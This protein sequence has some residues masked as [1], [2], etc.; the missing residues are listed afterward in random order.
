MKH[1]TYATILSLFVATNYITTAQKPSNPTP[2]QKKQWEDDAKKYEQMVR[3][4]GGKHLSSHEKKEEGN[5]NS[6]T[7][8]TDTSSTRTD[9]RAR[10]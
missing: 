5:Q 9:I 8:V 7:L 1:I 10:L 2:E 6:N 3:A 4:L